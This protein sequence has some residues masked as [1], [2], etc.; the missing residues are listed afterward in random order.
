M[1]EIATS[2]ADCQRDRLTRVPSSPAD[3]LHRLARAVEGIGRGR[4]ADPETILVEK[5]SLAAELRQVAREL[6]P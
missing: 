2:R 6:G 4:S 1:T 5:M 3:R